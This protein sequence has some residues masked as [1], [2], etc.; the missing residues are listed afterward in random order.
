M[1]LRS[2][3]TSSSADVT[4]TGMVDCFEESVGDVMQAL[5]KLGAE[6][7][8]R[9]AVVQAFLVGCQAALDADGVRFSVSGVRRLSHDV[10]L[11]LQRIRQ[12]CDGDASALETPEWEPFIRFSR[13]ITRQSTASHV[14]RGSKVAP[15]GVKSRSLLATASCFDC[16][17]W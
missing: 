17:S 13:Q 2:D 7:P 16:C 14:R 3:Y 6:A 11:L 10:E 15:T 12:A 9:V 4:S 5:E 1:K 8:A